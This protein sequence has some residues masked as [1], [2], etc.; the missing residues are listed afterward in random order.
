VVWTALVWVKIGT[1][2]SERMSNGSM[3][4]NER[5]EEMPIYLRSAF[6]QECHN[7]LMTVSLCSYASVLVC[8]PVFLC[9]STW[10]L[11]C[12]RISLDLYCSA[13]TV[14]TLL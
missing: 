12:I 14:T 1:S 9:S 5:Y 13:F 4:S 8:V 11:L 6:C 10:S 2:S 7:M 3:D